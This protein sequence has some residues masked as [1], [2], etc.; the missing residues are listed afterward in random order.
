MISDDIKRNRMSGWAWICSNWCPP[1]WILT[2]FIT[3]LPL[4]YIRESHDTRP[5]SPFVAS[6]RYNPWC[7]QAGEL[8]PNPGFARICLMKMAKHW[9]QDHL[10]GSILVWSEHKPCAF[11]QGSPSNPLRQGSFF[12]WPHSLPTAS[13]QIKGYCHSIQSCQNTLKLDCFRWQ[14]CGWD[15]D[16]NNLQPPSQPSQ[17]RVRTAP[18]I[19]LHLGPNLPTAPSALSIRNPRESHGK[20][21]IVPGKCHTCWISIRFFA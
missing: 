9:S 14:A 12:Q 16:L 4:S 19:S 21:G 10:S 11:H 7:Q 6:A 15:P 1:W 3:L 8:L 5:S 2:H 18:H 13:I 20:S 17:A